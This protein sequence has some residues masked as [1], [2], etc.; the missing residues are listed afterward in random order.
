MIYMIIPFIGVSIKD[1]F[2]TCFQYLVS[3]QNLGSTQI[4]DSILDVSATAN[5]DAIV[6]YYDIHRGNSQKELDRLDIFLRYI[7]EGYPECP[8]NLNADKFIKIADEFIEIIVGML[9]EWRNKLVCADNQ[10]CNIVY[11]K[12]IKEA[13]T[14]INGHLSRLNRIMHLVRS[15]GSASGKESKQSGPVKADAAGMQVAR[16]PVGTP[17]GLTTEGVPA[18]NMPHLVGIF[19]DPV[20]GESVNLVSCGEPD[21][22]KPRCAT[23]CL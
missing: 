10:Y 4:V 22:K 17:L 13:L 3:M 7:Q 12:T 20:S 14:F 18:A 19:S 5:V 15:S 2:I 6:N 23:V 9:L 11:K 16:Y 1:S 21:A 8:A